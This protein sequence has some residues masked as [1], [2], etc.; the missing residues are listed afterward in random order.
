MR[1]L[2]GKVAFIT[3]AARGQGRSHALALAAE[4]ADVIAVDICRQID[5]VPYPMASVA[6]LEETAQLVRALGG[7]IVTREADVRDFASLQAAVRAGLDEFGRL[8]IVVAN[9]GTVNGFAPAWEIEEEQFRDQ[10]EVCAAGAWRTIKATVPT[11]IEQGEG[12]AVV[13]TSSVSGLVAEI[14]IAHYVMSKHAVEGLMHNL[15]AELAPHNIRVNTVCPTSVNTP[16]IDNPAFS[17]LFA[18]KETATYAEAM[19]GMRSINALPIPYV[20]PEDVSKAVLFLAGNDGRFVTGISLPVDAG[21][22]MPYKVTHQG[23]GG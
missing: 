18:G 1:K 5:T 11:L 17:G 12:G 2:S 9:A 15:A 16:M 4:G 7:R 10:W 23:T 13:L 6:D 21:A 19:P 20:E 8:D 22:L 14:N 3:G